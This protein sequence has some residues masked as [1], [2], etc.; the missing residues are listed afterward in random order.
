MGKKVNQIHSNPERMESMIIG[1]GHTIM[2]GFL[3]TGVEPQTFSENFYRWNHVSKE[4]VEKLGLFGSDIDYNTYYPNLT[5]EDLTP[6]ADEFIEP[7][8][9]LLSA[10]I[11]SKNWNPT[12]FSQPGV[13]KASMR[14]LL[15]QTV[16]CDHST[17]IG[18][19]IGSV[20]QVMWQEGYKDGNFM[21]PAGI[22]GVLKIDGKANP[23]IAR[24]ILMDP[25]S[26]HS[27]SVTVQ[28]KWDKS[29]PGMDDRDFWDKLGT[30]DEKGNMIRK[31]VTEVVRYLET[32]LVS[33]GADSFAQKIGEDGKIINPEFA[34][35]TWTSF[36]EYQEDTKKA[37]YFTDFKEDIN[38]YQENNDTPPNNINTNNPLNN[39]TM[40]KELKEF[41][42]KLFGDN[43]LSLAEGQEVSTELALSA[44][45][46]LV[47]SKKTLE[48]SITNLT[49]E[50][51]QLSEQITQKDAE[52]AN[53]TAMATVGKN[54][55]AS[56]REEVVGNYKK[57]KGDKVDETIVT[58]LN[59]ETTGLQTLISL[60]KDYKAQLEEKFPL[61]CSKCGSHDVTRSS[62]VVE[63]PKKDDT[64]SNSE[65]PSTSDVIG[66]LYRQKMYNNK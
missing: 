5:K 28:F 61:T 24:G 37:Y 51:N 40:N 31:V 16:N 36:A 56:L 21:I 62:S 47:N 53:L 7:V 65:V 26:I 6:N 48:A 30:Y 4:S 17:D 15:G 55:I 39:N 1:S 12:D 54:H 66:S 23:R 64:T 14:M 35:R 18:N 45:Q 49:T 32:S 22:N 59:A 52:I 20:S 44:V 38:S 43:L 42:E 9:R 57:L 25:P 33:H 27:N 34:K 58:M 63:D 11:V 46:S 60:N 13:L 3:P 10:T 2:A 19:A 29:H 41:L 50:K 8:F